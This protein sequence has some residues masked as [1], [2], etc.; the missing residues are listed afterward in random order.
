M[1][2]K[3][4]QKKKRKDAILYVR[5]HIDAFATGIIWRSDFEE[6]AVGQTA[7][8][9]LNNFLDKLE[10]TNLW[11]GNNSSHFAFIFG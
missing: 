2:T 1:H 8:E 3:I 10:N 11:C 4:L 6:K 5:K 9:K 7:D